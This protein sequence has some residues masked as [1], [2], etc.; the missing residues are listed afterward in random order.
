MHVKALWKL[1]DTVQRSSVN[2][3][4]ASVS[5]GQTSVWSLYIVLESLPEVSF[6]F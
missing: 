3:V 4:T 5:Q 6:I 1:E 2:I